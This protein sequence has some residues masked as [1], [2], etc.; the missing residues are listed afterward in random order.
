MAMEREKNNAKGIIQI[1]KNTFHR[2]NNNF[3]KTAISFLSGVGKNA[4]G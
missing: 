1:L 3:T 4:G 2:V